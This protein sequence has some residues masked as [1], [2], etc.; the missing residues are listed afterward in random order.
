VQNHLA[1]SPSIKRGETKASM[2]T[3]FLSRAVKPERKDRNRC[4][5]RLT[6]KLHYSAYVLQAHSTYMQEREMDHPFQSGETREEGP[7]SLSHT[8]DW[9]VIH[10]PSLYLLLGNRGSLLR[11][12]GVGGGGLVVGVGRQNTLVHMTT[13]SPCRWNIGARVRDL[14]PPIGT[15]RAGRAANVPQERD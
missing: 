2:Q 9:K 4:P 5:T 15:L 7:K 3:L 10:T 11:A 8:V 12:E 1:R 14:A 6:G 13:A